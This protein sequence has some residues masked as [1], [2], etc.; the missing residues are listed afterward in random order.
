MDLGY[1]G[2]RAPT[3]MTLREPLRAASGEA[4]AGLVRGGELAGHSISP[5][6]VFNDAARLG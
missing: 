4:A 2:L 5:P 1:R 3:A 6:D